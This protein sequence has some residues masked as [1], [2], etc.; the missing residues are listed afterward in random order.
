M[1][2]RG[3]YSCVITFGGGGEGGV[4]GSAV[5]CVH[6]IRLMQVAVNKQSDDSNNIRKTV[7]RVFAI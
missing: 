6:L 4:K 3:F 2:R 1:R 7:L 5:G